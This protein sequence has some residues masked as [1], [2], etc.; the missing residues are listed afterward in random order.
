MRWITEEEEEE[1]KESSQRKARKNT[2]LVLLD[3]SSKFNFCINITVSLIN[4]KR[5]ETF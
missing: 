3:L 4:F 5:V 2:Q 1:E